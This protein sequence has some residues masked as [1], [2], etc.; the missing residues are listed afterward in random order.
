MDRRNT[1]MITLGWSFVAEGL[2]R[3]FIEPPRDSV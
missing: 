2:S 3:S 1:A